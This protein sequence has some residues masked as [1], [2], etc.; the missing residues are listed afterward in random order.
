MLIGSD[1]MRINGI[2][3]YEVYSKV[4]NLEQP[5]RNAKIAENQESKK[6]Q[7][8][9]ERQESQKSK[10]KIVSDAQRVVNET[11]SADEAAKLL[12]Q[13]PFDSVGRESDIRSLDIAA[14]VSDMQKD[15]V[16]E[17][18]QYFVGDVT[19]FENTEDGIVIQKS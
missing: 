17:Q 12:T 10:E 4:S 16:L 9:Q 18:Y 3:H 14:A 19:P 11:A 2:N 13:R 7:E 15:H 1:E 8:N 6:S 5:D